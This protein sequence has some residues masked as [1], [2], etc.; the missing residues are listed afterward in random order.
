M[1][2]T[3]DIVNYYIH[4]VWARGGDSDRMAGTPDRSRTDSDN[5]PG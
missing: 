2:T 5:R 3:D 4:A 1:M